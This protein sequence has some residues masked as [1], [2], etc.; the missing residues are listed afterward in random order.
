MFLASKEFKEVLDV[1]WQK[2]EWFTKLLANVYTRIYTRAPAELPV[3]IQC[4]N[5]DSISQQILRSIAK[6]FFIIYIHFHSNFSQISAVA[7]NDAVTSLE[8]HE[9]D[10]QKQKAAAFQNLM[11]TYMTTRRRGEGYVL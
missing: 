8:F 5:I 1:H 9:T 6:V 7:L 2:S 4:L 11:H 10:Q 3:E